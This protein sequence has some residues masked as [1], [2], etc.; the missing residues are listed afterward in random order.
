[1]T[2]MN[3][4]EEEAVEQGKERSGRE[5]GEGDKDR[6]CESDSFMKERAITCY[7]RR[8]LCV[9]GESGAV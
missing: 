3:Y 5:R 2:G 1:M 4:E 6:R 8:R 9:V 7:L